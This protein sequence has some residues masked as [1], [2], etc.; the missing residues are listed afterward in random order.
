MD[1]FEC[2]IVRVEIFE[3]S[4]A[5][6]LEIARVGGEGGFTCVVGKG[7]FETGDRAVYIPE[8]GIVPDDVLEELGLT[9]KLAGSK[10]NRVKAVKLRGVVSRGILYPLSGKKFDGYERFTFFQDQD[11]S[12][13]LGIKKYEPK[14]PQ[15]MSGTAVACR[16]LFGYDIENIQKHPDVFHEGDMVVFS[17]KIHGTFVCFAWIAGYGF[18]VA[19]KGMCSKRLAFDL[20]NE[21]NKERNLYCKMFGKMS[22]KFTELLD[23]KLAGRKD[24]ECIFLYGEIFGKGVQDLTYGSEHSFRAFDIAIGAHEMRSFCPYK[25]YKELCDKFDI[26]RVPDL[27]Y[28]EFNRRLLEFYT[29]GNSLLCENQIRE[30]IVVKSAKEENHDIIGR[31]VLK[32][33]SSDYLLRRGGT[34]LN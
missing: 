30:G 12:E 19:S 32:S 2:P 29:S 23:Y 27:H 14:V 25:E 4:N 33:V 1:D 26:P 18:A 16:G 21:K 17:E 10:H 20:Q 5:D 8:G 15:S 9:G 3:H 7:S 28:G 24:K 34:E 22:G 31:K 13:D 11:M 6:S